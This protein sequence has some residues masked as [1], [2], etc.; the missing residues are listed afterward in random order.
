MLRLSRGQMRDAYM[1]SILAY[2]AVNRC[3]DSEVPRD[4]GSTGQ[5][6][7]MQQPVNDLASLR[8]RSFFFFFFFLPAAWVG[9]VVSM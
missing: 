6:H 3:G 4:S 8:I 1:T 9:C 5:S 7:S 2:D